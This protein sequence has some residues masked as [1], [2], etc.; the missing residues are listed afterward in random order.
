MERAEDNP[1][2]RRS[3][4]HA[5]V[6]S[7]AHVLRLVIDGA[8]PPL[9][10]MRVPGLGNEDVHESSAATLNARRHIAAENHLAGGMPV[11]EGV[12]GA[13]VHDVVKALEGGRAAI[14]RPHR[15]KA[16]VAGAVDRGLRPFQAH[17]LVAGVQEAVRAGEIVLP[18]GQMQPVEQSLPLEEA[19]RGTKMAG[20]VRGLIAQAV[21]VLAI[22]GTIF[23][24]L[25]V[26][27]LRAR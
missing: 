16:L 15:R 13:F 5:R 24:V 22:A 23:T 12:N 11:L 20:S 17:L 9:S 4:D 6:S 21:F 27:V 25:L 19:K 3:A 18:E 10:K 2:G 1:S 7:S 14:L 26:M 8:T